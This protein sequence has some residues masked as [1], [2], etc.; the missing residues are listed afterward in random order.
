L[1]NPLSIEKVALRVYLPFATA[2]DT[3]N[4]TVVTPLRIVDDFM[5]DVTYEHSGQT[6][7]LPL[8]QTIRIQLS[9]N[10]TT[11]IGG[12]FTPATNHS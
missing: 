2:L 3:K 1:G 11:D 5:V 10:P 7:D 12:T 8:N 4:T 6:I 9:E